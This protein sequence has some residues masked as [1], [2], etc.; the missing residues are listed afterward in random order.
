MRIPVL[1]PSEV[2]PQDKGW[3]VL[4]VVVLQHPSITHQVE[5]PLLI[6]RIAFL[7]LD[8]GLLPSVCL[9]FGPEHDSL[10]QKDCYNILHLGHNSTTDDQL[11]TRTIL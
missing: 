10:L 8:L 6:R 2:S 9:W 4:S 7:T 1:T 11:I 5:E 3:A